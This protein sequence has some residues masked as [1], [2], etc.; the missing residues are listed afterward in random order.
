MREFF[1]IEDFFC[2][3]IKIIGQNIIGS[4]KMFN[5]RTD[6]AIEAGAIYNKNDEEIGKLN[7]IKYDSEETD[8]YKVTR[9]KVENENGEKLIGKPIGNYI[10]VDAPKISSENIEVYNKVAKQLKEEIENLTDFEGEKTVLVAG[11]GN[12]RMTPD[13]FG[14]KVISALSVTRH[15]YSTDRI[16]DYQHKNKVCAIAPGVLGTTGIETGEI[17]KGVVD[18]VK[19]DIVICIDA[20]A[21]RSLNRI[22]TSFQMCDTGI[23]PGSGVGN[24]RNALN[25]DTL[26]VPVI[27]IGVP[28]VVDAA[29]VANDTMDKVYEVVK[30]YSPKMSSD[31]GFLAKLNSEER[32]TLIREILSPQE[33]NLIVSPKDIDAVID[34]VSYI[35]AD[36]L[37]RLF[38]N[39]SETLSI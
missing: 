31:I 15:I 36:A 1:C 11:L 29:T 33:G 12:E 21:T 14:P 24:R 4:D 6:M 39:D 20:L 27:A 17:I 2:D 16:S 10:T 30:A 19:P 18:R 23:V 7:G 34:C 5:I 3:F 9:V 8:F 32:Y 26:G 28:T 22:S 37:N 38:G 35:V 25:I 13:A